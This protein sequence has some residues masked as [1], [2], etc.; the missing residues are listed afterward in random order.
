MASASASVKAMW[1]T[2]H[3][4]SDTADTDTGPKFPQPIHF[5]AFF[6]LAQLIRSR[7]C[8]TPDGVT[9]F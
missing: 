4:T 6:Y 5:Q 2:K 7:R 3:K 9:W 1:E 8:V